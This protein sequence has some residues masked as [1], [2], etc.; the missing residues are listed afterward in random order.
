MK[1][2]YYEKFGAELQKI[3]QSGKTVTLLLHACCAPCACFPLEL[4][5]D[6]FDITL[7]YNNS[8]IYPMSEY[9]LRLKELVEYIEG[10]NKTR[11]I[12]IKL[13]VPT[14]NNVEYN[15][16]LGTCRAT[17]KEGGVGCFSCYEKRMREGY[18]FAQAHS[19]DY[20]ATV[21][22]ISRQKNSQVLN[23]IGEKLSQEFP[24][25]KFLYADFKKKGGQQR[26]DE[27]SKDMYRQQYCGC[28]Y[29]YYEYLKR[30]EIL[31]KKQ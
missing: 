17:T 8:N 29:S 6:N 12:P 4:L 13:L 23:E 15:M 25:T 21:M 28:V 2:Y 30:D 3:K 10:I 27:L 9:Q 22:S 11:R 24:N 19:F 18:A 16:F 7:Y 20:Y 5:A 31:N 14:Y 1:L 26:R